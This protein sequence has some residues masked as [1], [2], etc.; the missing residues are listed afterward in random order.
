MLINI[1]HPYEMI[2]KI[3]NDYFVINYIKYASMAMTSL[4]TFFTN[5]EGTA[6]CRHIFKKWN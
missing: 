3:L 2:Y 4:Y 5:T 6:D 1:L